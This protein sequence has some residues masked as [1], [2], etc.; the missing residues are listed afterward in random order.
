VPPRAFV[1]RMRIIT[2]MHMKNFCFLIEIQFHYDFVAFGVIGGF[3]DPRLKY[4]RLSWNGCGLS[5]S[6]LGR[7]RPMQDQ[8]N[9]I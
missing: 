1:S 4:Y 2:S 8:T 9:N 7:L 6:R 5:Q 3:D